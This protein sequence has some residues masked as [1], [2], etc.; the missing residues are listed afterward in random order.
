VT[1]FY[2]G[3]VVRLASDGTNQTLVDGGTDGG[4]ASGYPLG[5]SVDAAQNVWVGLYG[6]AAFTELVGGSG[7]QAA[8]TAL[9]P[10]NGYGL[11][12][13]LQYPFGI[14]PDQSGNIWVSNYGAN[15]LTM[16]FGLATPTARPLY[17]SPIAP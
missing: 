13:K 2:G 15:T 10:A 12:A 11:D 9:S 6:G 7:Y 17:S 14:L 1:S 8:G 4:I 16:F 3:D 5:V